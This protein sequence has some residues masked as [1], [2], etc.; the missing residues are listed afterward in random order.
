MTVFYVRHAEKGKVGKPSENVIL[1]IRIDRL[2][3]RSSTL[4]QGVNI[5]C[6]KEEPA[7]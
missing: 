3:G 5:P 6:F 1:G 2:P 7:N 4:P